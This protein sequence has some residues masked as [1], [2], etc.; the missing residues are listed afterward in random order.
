VF[1]LLFPFYDGVDGVS[2]LHAELEKLSL[3]KGYFGVLQAAF[4]TQ[5]TLEHLQ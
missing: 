4:Y 5:A 2:C 3:E 1:S